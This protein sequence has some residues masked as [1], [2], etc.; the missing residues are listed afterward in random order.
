M[1]CSLLA[2]LLLTSLVTVPLAAQDERTHKG[3]WIGFGLGAGVNL[4]AGLDDKSLWGG[5]GYLRLGG[6]PKQQLLLGG[7]VIGWTVDNRNVTLNRGNAHFVAM[8]YPS[9]KSSFYLKG[10]IGGASIGRESNAGSTR[11]TTTKGGFGAGAGLGYEIRIGRNIYL[12]PAADFLFQ[13]FKKEIDPVLGPVP[14]T[15]T[16]LLFNLGLTFH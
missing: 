15:N 11:T 13:A 2:G 9:A 5:N 4:P 6:T 12:V 16:L 8:Y 1:R 14:G 3:F 7:E 10:G